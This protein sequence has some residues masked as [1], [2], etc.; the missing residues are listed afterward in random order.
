MK[1]ESQPTKIINTQTPTPKPI[2]SGRFPAPNSHSPPSIVSFEISP[3]F[4]VGLGAD[5]A[6]TRRSSVC[7]CLCVSA[8]IV[9]YNQ[10]CYKQNVVVTITIIAN[11]KETMKVKLETENYEIFLTV[12]F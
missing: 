1:R 12:F 6:S 5:V 2:V 10:W 9:V 3:P 8:D 7:A 11:K 4:K